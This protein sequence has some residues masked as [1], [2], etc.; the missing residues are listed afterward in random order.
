MDDTSETQKSGVT[1]DLEELDELETQTKRKI[2][3]LSSLL[4][5]NERIEQRLLSLEN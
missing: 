4:K 2:N 1:R 5:E 3:K